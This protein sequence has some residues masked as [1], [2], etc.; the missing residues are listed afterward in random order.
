MMCWMSS[1]AMRESAAGRKERSLSGRLRSS[2][3]TPS[4]VYLQASRASSR[5]VV[6]AVIQCPPRTR[7]CTGGALRLL[8]QLFH[9][10]EIRE[11][12]VVRIR[13]PP[14]VRRRQDLADGRD[15]RRVLGQKFLPDLL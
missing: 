9:D 11:A 12:P 13:V 6:R 14:A 2:S 3:I 7:E 1:K 4:R 8:L 15:A 10:V 5:T